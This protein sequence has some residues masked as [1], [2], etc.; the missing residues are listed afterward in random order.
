MK[1]TG[2]SD[3]Q[4][5]MILLENS[6]HVEDAKWKV[7]VFQGSTLKGTDISPTHYEQA[8]LWM[9]ELRFHFQFYPETF[10]LAVSILNRMLASVKAQVKYLRCIA[11]TCL[12]LAAKTNEE[13]EVDTAK[14]I[15]CKELVDQ[16]LE[17]LSPHNPVYIFI[18]SSKDLQAHHSEKPP[19]CCPA[20]CNPQP[21]TQLSIKSVPDNFISAAEQA[22]QQIMET[23]EFYDGFRYLYN[24]DSIPEAGRISNVITGSK[25]QLEEGSSPCPLLQSPQ[26]E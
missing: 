23:D 15:Q 17:M 10:G 16:H 25:S 20:G 11:V 18:S 3:S 22:H 19:Y 5:L 1:C 2:L 14:F 21:G 24:E 13:D 9:E 7:P 26:L 6:L 4:R 12:Y 8:V